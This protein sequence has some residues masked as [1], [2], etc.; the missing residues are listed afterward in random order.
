M[1]LLIANVADCMMGNNT[2]ISRDNLNID[3]KCNNTV[4]MQTIIPALAILG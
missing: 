2:L 1:Y 4:G 3:F